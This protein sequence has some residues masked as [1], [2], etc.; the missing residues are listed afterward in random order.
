M[1]TTVTLQPDVAAEVER[2]RREQGLGP[3]DALNQLAR[4]GMVDQPIDTLFV[5]KTH[6]VALLMDISNVH[7]ALEIAES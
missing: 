2:L 5:Q 6:D 4:R 1:R 3:T 7:D